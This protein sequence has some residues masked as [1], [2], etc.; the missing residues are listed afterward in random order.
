[1]KVSKPRLLL[2]FALL[3][4]PAAQLG[5]FLVG[6]TIS[7]AFG[8]ASIPVGG[9]TSL[10]FL[11]TNPSGIA[12]TG[13]VVANILPSGLIISTPNGLTGS[14]GGGTITAT[15]GS[16]AVSL[17]GATLAPSTSCTFSVNVT[18]TSTGTQA[19]TTGQIASDQTSEGPTANASIMV[20][21]AL[22]GTPAPSSLLLVALGI[23]A[24]LAWSRRHQAA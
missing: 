1:M 9:S 14:C 2:C 8:T 18:G 6:P 5:A 3:A 24:M 19:D 11:I 7:I 20:T 16:S 15:A 23:L 13:I 12:F 17:S 4:V 21:P 10:T 22:P